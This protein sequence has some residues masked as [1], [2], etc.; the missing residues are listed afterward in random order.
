MVDHVL[1]EVVAD[2][3]G[4]PT[5]AVQQPLH[6][7]RRGIPDLLGQLPPVLPFHARE[8]GPQVGGRPS[9]GL[10][11]PEPTRNPGHDGLELRLPILD[12]YAICGGCRASSGF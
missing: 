11:S 12:V 6:P 4:V 10:H 3:V 8:Q 2:P 7:V 9:P 5:V 1:A